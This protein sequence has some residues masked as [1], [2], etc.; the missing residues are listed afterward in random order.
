M[1][2]DKHAYVVT[3][4]KVGWTSHGEHY[5]GELLSIVHGFGDSM[6]EKIAWRA[7]SHAICEWD[8][9]VEVSKVVVGSDGR[10]TTGRKILGSKGYARTFTESIR[11]LFNF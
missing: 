10:L 4:S 7:A 5:V 1:N 6:N 8:V 9:C 3:V 2:Q 11:A